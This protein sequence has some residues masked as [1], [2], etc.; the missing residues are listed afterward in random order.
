[1]LPASPGS[2]GFPPELERHPRY[3]VAALVGRGGMGTVYRA[4]HTLMGRPVALKVID[5]RLLEH[6]GSLAR[7]RQEVMAAARLSHPNIVIA[8]DAEQAGAHHFLVME[9]VE[10][11]NL[12]DY[13]RTRGRL[14]AGEACAY[15]R[16]AALGLQHAFAKG[17]VHRDIKPHNLMLTPDGQVKVLDFGLARFVSEPL[18][19]G[20]ACN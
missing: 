14:G 12:A 19:E 3:R 15:V 7:F 1:S 18:P 6:A 2:L 5:P 8:Y 16:Q 10:G 11:T 20:D 4:E 13:L 17:M 9:F